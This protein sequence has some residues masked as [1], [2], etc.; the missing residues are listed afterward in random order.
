M[1]P[2]EEAGCCFIN[3]AARIDRARVDRIEAWTGNEQLLSQ[4]F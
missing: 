3:G 4:I 2:R 1:L